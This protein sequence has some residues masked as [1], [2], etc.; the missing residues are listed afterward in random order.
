MESVTNGLLTIVNGLF[1][2]TG[3][4]ISPLTLMGLI[5]VVSY[6]WLCL[7]E[8]DEVDRQGTKPEVGRH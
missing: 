5:M 3:R 1:D 8:L 6:I 2:L 7:I 4:V